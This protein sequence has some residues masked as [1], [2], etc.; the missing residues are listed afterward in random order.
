MLALSPERRMPS[1]LEDLMRQQEQQQ[2][3]DARRSKVARAE[4]DRLRARRREQEAEG[5]KW[6]ADY[7]R[8]ELPPG[9]TATPGERGREVRVHTS[10]LPPV[11][12]RSGHQTLHPY[13]VVAI[14]DDLRTLSVSGLVPSTLTL[15][16]NWPPEF[17]ASDGEAQFL[18]YLAREVRR[19]REDADSV[20]ADR[21]LRAAFAAGALL[22]GIGLGALASYGLTGH[23]YEPGLFWCVVVLIAGYGLVGALGS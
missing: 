16:G 11:E 4:E 13:V 12:R 10:W 6:L 9:F 7:I 20:R 5:A 15:T 3:E 23:Y 18:S 21:R 14:A 19:V 22:V 8:R 17:A 2:A 1:R